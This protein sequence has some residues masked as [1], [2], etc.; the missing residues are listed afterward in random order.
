MRRAN[1]VVHQPDP[2]RLR[3]IETVAQQ[4]EFPRLGGTHQPGHHPGAAEISRIA[5]FAERYAELGGTRGDA[6]IAGH[7]QSK[8]GAKSRAVQHADD[9]FRAGP[10]HLRDQVHLAQALDPMLERHLVPLL[11][12]L[13]VTAGAERPAR[14]GNHDGADLGVDAQAR[15][16]F[17]Q[18]RQ[19]LLG[20]RIQAVRA[21]QGQCG[22]PVLNCFGHVGHSC[23]LLIGCSTLTRTWQL[24]DPAAR[25]H[26]GWP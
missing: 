4:I 2:L 9:H 1:A 6:Q 20:Q 7:R 12:A 23:L 8:P 21:V 24:D 18:H 17:P 5:D 14:A 22:N 13:D 3:R 16:G 10:H 25:T 11:H 15:N 19:K 26:H